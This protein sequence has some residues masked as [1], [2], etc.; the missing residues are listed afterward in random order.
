MMRVAAVSP[1]DG[2]RKLAEEIGHKM[3][4]LA[5]DRQRGGWYDVVERQLRPGQERYRFAWHDRKAWWQQEQAIL[6]YLILAGQT[7]DEEFRR[8]AYEAAAF[9]NAFFLDHDEGGV[10]FNVLADGTPYLVGTERLKGSHSMSMYHAAELCYL[11]TV[12]QHL[13]LQRQPLTLWFRPRPDAFPDR[14]LRVAPDAL[15]AGS[16]RLDWVEIDGQPYS[17]FDPAALTVRLPDSDGPSSVRVH[18]SA[19]GS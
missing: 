2:Y 18:L 15:P 19:T 14:V 3:P 5:G 9:Y 4:E 17:D 13:L 12:Y 16:V 6:A 11:A 8:Q 7:G 10:Y 1:D